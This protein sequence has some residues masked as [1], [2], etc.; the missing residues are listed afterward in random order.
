MSFDSDIALFGT[1]L[2]PLVA[3]NFLIAQGKSVLLLNPDRDFFLE[4]SELPLDPMLTGSVDAFRL[5]QSSLQSV[6]GDVRPDFPGAVEAWPN[7]RA[8]KDADSRVAA[9]RVAHAPHVRQRGR[10]WMDLNPAGDPHF[11]SLYY[12]ASEAGLNPQLLDDL[13]ATARFPGHS[14][15]ISQQC[16]GIQ[17]PNLCD[18]DVA[19][20][21]LGLLE[22]LRE[23]L[24]TERLICS[25]TQVEPLPWGIRFHAQEAIHSA[26][27]REG[28]L[29]FWTPRLHRWVM[30]LAKS[31]DQ[32]PPLMPEGV[33]QWEEWM[34][35][36]KDG[37][38]F[39]QIGIW[40][41]LAV[42]AEIEGA[43]ESNPGMGMNLL[44]TL[45]AGPL[46]PLHRQEGAWATSEAFGD[47]DG[48]CREFLS[49]NRFS[50]RQMKPKAI[51]EWK[52]A[53]PW[54]ARFNELR[55]HVVP[56]SDGPLFQVVRAAREA[57]RQVTS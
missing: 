25:A 56:R 2:A 54:I 30:N 55:I 20:Y 50:V 27:L 33:R 22:Y 32:R 12:E 40:K 8:A 48:L 4:D 36:S 29:V 49:W 18:V 24:G 38:D 11:E 34:I 10:L 28:L 5:K 45:R 41:N 42:W 53:S 43:P 14:R 7:P 17:V 3:A 23:K 13:Q 44:S 1:G 6:L 52:G 19:R 21:R 39:E 15:K 51:F 46:E 37:L 35:L 16:R 9:Y 26:K 47:L 31:R 57:S